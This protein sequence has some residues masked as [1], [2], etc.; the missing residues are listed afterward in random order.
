IAVAG[1]HAE[2]QIQRR[3]AAVLI[4]LIIPHGVGVVSQHG[5]KR[6][7]RVIEIQKHLLSKGERKSL[8]EWFHADC[9][10]S[11]DAGAE[12]T[13]K[14]EPVQVPEAELIRIV[15]FGDLSIVAERGG[16][17][18]GVVR[19]GAMGVD[20]AVDGGGSG[21]NIDAAADRHAGVDQGLGYR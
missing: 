6:C 10:L 3:W 21:N 20:S 5:G 17:L 1:P 18:E 7:A 4:V 8:L 14:V 11:K 13:L 9:Q 16:E 19:I 12:I 2:I 15:V